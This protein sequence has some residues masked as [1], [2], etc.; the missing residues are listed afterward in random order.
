MVVLNVI[1]D[2]L[3]EVEEEVIVVEWHIVDV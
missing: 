1:V 2:V 3:L